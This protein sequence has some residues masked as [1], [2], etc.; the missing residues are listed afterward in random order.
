MWQCNLTQSFLPNTAEQTDAA[1]DIDAAPN[2]ALSNH[3]RG[4]AGC[5]G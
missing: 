1:A 5:I 4:T 2:T 3:Q